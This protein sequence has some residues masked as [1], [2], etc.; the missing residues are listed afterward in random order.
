[1]ALQATVHRFAVNVSDVDR[2]VYESLDLRVARHPSETI[3]F[4]L[5]RVLAYALSFEEGIAFSKGGLSDVDEAPLT[6]RDP[7][8]VLLAWL[9]IGL[10]SAERLHKASKAARRVAVFTAH[11]P[12]AIAREL[13]SRDIHRKG[14]LE[15]LRIEPRLLD[16]LE[17]YVERHTALAVTRNDGRLYVDVRGK[18]FEGAI[19]RLPTETS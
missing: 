17:P 14:E 6:V 19:D 4:M 10:P 3:R 16:D 8:G 5:L 18:T 1:M 7:T 15:V 12:V 2:G 11:D 9:D 13:G